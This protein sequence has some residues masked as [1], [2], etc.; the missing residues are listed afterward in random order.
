M[1]NRRS[2]QR[3]R[4]LKGAVALFNQ[5]H[6][7]LHCKVRNLSDTGC[8]IEIDGA[9]SMPDTFTLAVELDGLEVACRVVWRTKTEVGVTFTGP[10]RSAVR[11]IQSLE[12]TR[13]GK[14]PSLRRKSV[15]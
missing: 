15:A 4:V 10:P 2:R 7:T 8:R 12:P 6:S 13:P 11:R 9:V 3:R 1:D 5:R 14:K